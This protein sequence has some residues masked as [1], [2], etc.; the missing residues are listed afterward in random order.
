MNINSPL[1]M[2]LPGKLE[3]FSDSVLSLKFSWIVKPRN[4]LCIKPARPKIKTNL[5]WLDVRKNS[6]LENVYDRVI[7]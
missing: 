2:S 6:I 5:L 1:K 4:G 7:N 3:I